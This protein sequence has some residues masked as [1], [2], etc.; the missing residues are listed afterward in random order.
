METVI[1]GSQICSVLGWIFL[2]TSWVWRNKADKVRELTMKLVLAT[3]SSCFF[4]ANIIHWFF[5]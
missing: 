1:T 5:G 3:A 4:I 2:L